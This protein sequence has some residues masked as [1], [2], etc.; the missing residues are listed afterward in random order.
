[1][2]KETAKNGNGRVYT[3]NG[4]IGVGKSFTCR[5]WDSISKKRGTEIVMMIPEET[6][7][8]NPF[9]ED[10]YKDKQLV[11][12]KIQMYLLKQRFDKYQDVEKTIN[13]NPKDGRAIIGLLDQS[14]WSDSIFGN[15]NEKNMP[16]KEFNY[17]A[18]EREEK[19]ERIEYP[20]K[21]FYLH[22]PPEVCM[23]RIKDRKRPGEQWIT[24]DYLKELQMESL[25]WIARMK[26]HCEVIELDWE[27]L[28]SE[29]EL[30]ALYNIH[31]VSKE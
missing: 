5:F 28:P 6:L 10:F 13:D 4:P 8:E 14:V 20:K 17:Y 16:S 18:S 19:F 12:Y 23:K 11:A 21:I 30:I 29:K 2:E 27:K 1:M 31:F 9:L 7:S 26:K 22:A 24:L 25:L 15:V 3:V